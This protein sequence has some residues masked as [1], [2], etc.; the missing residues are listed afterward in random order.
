MKKFT[1]VLLGALLFLTAIAPMQ[2]VNADSSLIP[3]LNIKPFNIPNNDAMQFVS[4]MKLGWNLGNTLDAINANGLSN[5][6]AY[7][8]SW[9]G[10]YTTKKMI[11]TLKASGF[12][13]VRIPV[14]WH[15]HVSGSDYKISDAWMNRVKE[16]VDYGIS[17]NMYVIL[18]VHHDTDKAY[19]FPSSSYIDNSKKYLSSV[20]SQIANKFSNYDNHLIF[21]GMNEPR[22]VGHKYEWWFPDL[23]DADIADSIKCINQL[24]QVFVNAVRATGGNNKG[25]YLMCPGYDASTDG[26]TNQYFS[27]PTDISGNV[28]KIIVSVH[29]YSPYN[30]ALQATTEGGTDYWSVNDSTS[31]N[32]ITSFMDNL[33]NKYTSKGIPVVIGEFGAVNRN[34]NLKARVEYHSYYIAAARARGISCFYWDNNIFSG[35]GE[36]FGLLDRNACQI[37]FPEIVAG[38]VKY[39]GS[40]QTDEAVY[41]DFNSDKKVDVLDFAAFKK[42]LLDPNHAYNKYYDLNSDN[43]V[44]VMDFAIMKQYLLGIKTKLPV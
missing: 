14:S 43:S 31:V 20:W 39:A 35:N 44:D 33:Y 5:E 6:L 22:L 29:A 10:V 36:L 34:N 38:M 37:K 4:D 19:C 13:A 3:N 25:R 23:N 32:G 40:T 11:D 12:N 42:Y 1:A 26:A 9:C 18:N 27:L 24:N 21:E 15:N 7:E 30:F 41:G 17:N 28:N 2:N 16:V 8:A